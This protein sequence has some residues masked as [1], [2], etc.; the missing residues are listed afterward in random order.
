MIKP[1]HEYV[2]T[3]ISAKRYD[4]MNEATSFDKYGNYITNY[5]IDGVKITIS[6]YKGKPTIE[7]IKSEFLPKL[8]DDIKVLK[9][10]WDKVIEKVAQEHFNYVKDCGREN[11]IKKYDTFEKN[12]KAI[13]LSVVHYDNDNRFSL[14]FNS[15]VAR[16]DGHSIF[17]DEVYIINGHVKVSY[18]TFEG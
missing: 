17:V 9:S 1:I 11:Y 12:K 8:D 14:V 15:D 16:A 5:S 10:E 3:L 6:I 13:K 7:E 18:V 2:N 4:I